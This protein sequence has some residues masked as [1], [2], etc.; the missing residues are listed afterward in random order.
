[1]AS[2]R[3]DAPSRLAHKVLY[4]LK[5]AKAD[6]VEFQSLF[7]R[8]MEK[9]DRSFCRIKPGGPA[10]DWKSDGYAAAD[11]AIYQC[12]APEIIRAKTTRDKIAEDFS[13]AQAYWGDRLKRWV[14]VVNKGGLPAEVIAT[15]ADLKQAQ[16]PTI[17]IDW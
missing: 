14:F 8:I 5:I 9:H 12:Y 10:G 3:R 2:D 13:G 6:G 15:L 16:A 1:M 17:G 7:E 11:G 4:D